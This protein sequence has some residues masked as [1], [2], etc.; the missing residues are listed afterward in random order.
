MKLSKSEIQTL[1]A[2]MDVCEKVQKEEKEG[3]AAHHAETAYDALD[4]LIGFSEGDE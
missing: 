3:D 1:Q 2:A 4:S